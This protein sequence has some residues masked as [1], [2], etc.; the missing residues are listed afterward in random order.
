MLNATSVNAARPCPPRSRTLI[1]WLVHFPG[2]GWIIL[3]HWLLIGPFL[4]TVMHPFIAYWPTDFSRSWC[5]V[6]QV[7]DHFTDFHCA[8]HCDNWGFEESELRYWHGVSDESSAQLH[9]W[10]KKVSSTT[11]T[12]SSSSSFLYNWSYVFVSF[13]NTQLNNVVVLQCLL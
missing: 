3:L 1:I 9:Q 10:L 4:M 6:I 5:T 13:I 12:S 8:F 7:A 2:R 11:T